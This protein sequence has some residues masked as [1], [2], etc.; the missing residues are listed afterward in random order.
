MVLNADMILEYRPVIC[1]FICRCD[2]RKCDPHVFVCR[3]EIRIIFQC[4]ILY[5][6]VISECKIITFYVDQS[7]LSVCFNSDLIRLYHLYAFLCRCDVQTYDLY[8]FYVL[9]D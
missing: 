5:V 3:C 9:H 4:L 2:M 6:V 8:D 1:V 7:I